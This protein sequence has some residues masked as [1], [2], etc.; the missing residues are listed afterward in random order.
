MDLVVI[1]LFIFPLLFVILCFFV[2]TLLFVFFSPLFS[3]YAFSPS[4]V[5]VCYPVHGQESS[6]CYRTCDRNSVLRLVVT[7][8][9]THSR[10][11]NK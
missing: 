9:Y 2:C 7:L 4:S 3:L 8:V 1:C 10:S 11:L 6:C 5:L